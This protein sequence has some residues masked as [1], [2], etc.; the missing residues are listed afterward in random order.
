M[1]LAPEISRGRRLK[2]R[3][4]VNGIQKGSRSLGTVATLAMGASLCGVPGHAPDACRVLLRRWAAG[5]SPVACLPHCR[6]RAV[7]YVGPRNER[8]IEKTTEAEGPPAA[9]PRR[10]RPGRDRGD[11]PHGRDHPPRLRTLRLRA[12]GDA[13]HRI[14]RR[15]REVP[16]RPGPA[17][18]GRLLLPGR[19]R[20][21]AVAA[22]RPDGAACALRRRAP[23]HRAH[24]A[25]L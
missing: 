1:S 17:E 24:R 9:R 4:A 25:P 10:P 2:A 19:R 21:V 5:T 6:I 8:K 23:R 15:A 11:A 3:L 12:G 16:A 13:G 14:Y 7:C 20:A 22:L 18:R